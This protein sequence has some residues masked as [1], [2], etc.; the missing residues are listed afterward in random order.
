MGADVNALIQKHGWPTFLNSSGERVKALNEPFWAGFVAEQY[1]LVHEPDERTFYAY[2]EASGLYRPLTEDA[3]RGMLVALVRYGARE[4]GTDDMGEGLGEFTSTKV[5]S[6]VIAHARSIAEERAFNNPAANFIHCQNCVLELCEDGSFK[7]HEFSPKLRSRNGSPVPYVQGAKCERFLNEVLG[8]I[9]DEDR[10][11]IQKIFGQMLLGANIAQKILLLHGLAGS[12]KS[13]L[14]LILQAIVGAQNITELRTSHLDQRFEISRYLGKS[15]L[16]GVDVKADFLSGPA[17][18]RI[19]GLTGGD[20][21]DAERKG[22]NSNFRMHGRFNILVTS[23]SRLRLRLEG[24][25]SAWRRR[26][27][28]I[29]YDVERSTQT[30]RDFDRVI[31]DAEAPGIL[32]WGLEGLAKLKADLRTHGDIVLSGR[33]LKLVENVI[34]ESDSLRLFLTRSI[35]GSDGHDLTVGEITSAYFGFCI[36][37]K[38]QPMSQGVVGRA[39]ELLM[40]EYFGVSQAHSIE[41]EGKKGHRGYR[42]V[43]FR[44]ESEE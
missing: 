23:N 18:S 32:A 27:I 16:V 40:L 38:W 4:W 8:W 34:E 9:R 25:T 22:S 44:T 6:G 28:L 5:L 1:L 39:L 37:Q 12:G 11:V 20:F 36:D 14:A 35:I 31:L 33:Q 19:K 15:L 30:I 42:R 43:R 7:V 13:T 17:V 2:E 21:L 41:R 10:E 24:D 29:E 26:L 3:I